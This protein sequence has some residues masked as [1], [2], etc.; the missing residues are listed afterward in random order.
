MYFSINMPWPSVV[1]LILP[2]GNKKIWQ[3]LWICC[4][5]NWAI[6]IFLQLWQAQ[7]N[8]GAW[9]WIFGMVRRTV[10][11][12]STLTLGPRPVPKLLNS[13]TEECIMTGCSEPTQT[14]VSL[15]H[16]LPTG[17]HLLGSWQ[18]TPEAS[19]PYHNPPQQH[20][21][22]HPVRPNSGSVCCITV[23]AAILQSRR[24]QA[25]GATTA[26]FHQCLFFEYNSQTLYMI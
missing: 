21:L 26:C 10:K 23:T 8:H 25:S 19:L 5:G 9:M 14:L 11:K 4:P 3:P 17:Q 7:Q 2:V 6:Y 24:W 12:N 16:Q 18:K 1:S 15:Q 22:L 13:G 20:S